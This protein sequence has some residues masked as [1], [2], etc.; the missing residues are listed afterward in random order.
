MSLEQSRVPETVDGFAP[1]EVKI[2]TDQ[3]QR[4]MRRSFSSDFSDAEPGEAVDAVLRGLYP[5]SE[6]RLKLALSDAFPGASWQWNVA[7]YSPGSKLKSRFVRV[8]WHASSADGK[9]DDGSTAPV[10]T[11]TLQVL[12]VVSAE[13]A[14]EDG[15]TYLIRRTISIA[16][17]RPLGGPN[18]WPSVTVLATA[19]GADGCELL[20]TGTLKPLDDVERLQNDVDEAAIALETEGV[21][22]PRLPT[23]DEVKDFRRRC[24]SN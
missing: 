9:L 17:A 22:Q 24:E 21:V 8:E 20:E 16:G 5:T 6:Y 15:S 19:W 12:A 2:F 18:W 10:L 3:A 4:I 14:A 13:R 11:V 23:P 1:R 7:S